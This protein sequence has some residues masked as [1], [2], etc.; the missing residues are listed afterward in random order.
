MAKFIFNLASV[1]KQRLAVE[2]TRQAVVAGLEAKRV[3]LEEQLRGCQ[4]AIEASRQS[5]RDLLGAS[6]GPD[7]SVA[8]ADVR[9][10]GMQAAASLAGEATAR[11]TVIQLAGLHTHLTRARAELAQAMKDRRAIELLRDRRFEEWKLEQRRIETNQMDEIAQRMSQRAQ[12]SAQ[13]REEA[14]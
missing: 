6:A 8:A 2:R 9:G 12:E 3:E 10:A 13:N 5:W 11:K 4:R 7:G 1:L 14:A